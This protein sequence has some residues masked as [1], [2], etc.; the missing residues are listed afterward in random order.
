MCVELADGLDG[1]DYKV[2]V[3]LME[4]TCL[5]GGEAVNK[6]P[7]TVFQLN[8]RQHTDALPDLEDDSLSE[9]L[10][11]D[12]TTDPQLLQ[13]PFNIPSPSSS[14]DPSDESVAPLVSNT[15]PELPKDD[16]SSISFLFS[17]NDQPSLSDHMQLEAP[18]DSATQ[19]QDDD[20]AGFI[21]F[22]LSPMPHSPQDFTISDALGSPISPEGHLLLSHFIDDFVKVA[23]PITNA[24]SPWQILY[25]PEALSTVGQLT[26]RTQPSSASLSLL[27]SLMV[28]SAFHL[29]RLSGA[30]PG[31]G[32][33]WRVAESY[34]E[35][36]MSHIQVSLRHE[37]KGPG[38][39][40]YKTLLMALLTM[41]TACVSVLP[42]PQHQI[43]N[44]A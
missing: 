41:V 38:K 20:P 12:I 26:L 27:C 21:N 4:E 3:S 11:F 23:S 31:C 18:G 40:K 32:Y 14:S 19:D 13:E 34:Q 5:A 33:W 42:H 22:V 35:K 16:F 36:A 2:T 25:F 29:D 28:I 43:T 7:F 44:G 15:I 1:N 17:P 8:T 37:V 30:E 9:I 10:S 39:A 24:K 6:G